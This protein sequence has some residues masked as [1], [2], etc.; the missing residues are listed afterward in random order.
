[1]DGPAAFPPSGWSR[2]I[3]RAVI[4]LVRLAIGTG[5]CSPCTLRPFTRP[6]NS[7][8]ACPVD[9]QGR[10]DGRGGAG[11]RAAVTGAG[12]EL[13]DGDGLPRAPP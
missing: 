2:R 7:T 3:T 13:D 10:A 11:G 12:L 6:V 1:M 4:T 9:G 8:A 5:R